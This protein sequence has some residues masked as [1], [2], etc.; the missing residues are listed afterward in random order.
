MRKCNHYIRSQDACLALETLVWLVLLPR[1]SLHR[2][3]SHRSRL[4]RLR[5]AVCACWDLPR[6]VFHLGR[7]LQLAAVVSALL[8]LHVDQSHRWYVVGYDCAPRGG[9]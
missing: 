5:E 4:V 1:R 6:H 3:G 2:C 8:T 7:N 9:W